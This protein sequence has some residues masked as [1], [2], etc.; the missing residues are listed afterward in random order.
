MGNDPRY[1]D[2]TIRLQLPHFKKGGLDLT[3]FFEGTLNL[4]ISPLTFQIKQPNFTF[5]TVA[6]SPFIP[7]ENFFFFQASLLVKEIRYPCFIYMPDPATKTDHAQPA[8]MLEV[9]AEKIEN[10]TYGDEVSLDVAEEALIFT[11]LK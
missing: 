6:W 11:T 10:V 3:A 7:P 2:G 1:P 9:M 5:Q 4:D 8:H